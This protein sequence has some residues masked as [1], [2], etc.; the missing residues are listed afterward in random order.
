ME[1]GAQANA[2]GLR[3]LKTE[4]TELGSNEGAA[5]DMSKNKHGV[6]CEM[7]NMVKEEP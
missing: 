1:P 7:N 2:D 3:S 4:E 5:C 6:Q